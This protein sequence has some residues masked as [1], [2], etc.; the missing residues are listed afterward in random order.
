MIEGVISFILGFV[1]F[2]FIKSVYDFIEGIHSDRKRAKRVKREEEEYRR[3]MEERLDNDYAWLKGV[4]S[5]REDALKVVRIMAYGSTAGQGLIVMMEVIS[6]ELG[7]YDGGIYELR[8]I[9]TGGFNPD[10]QVS[11][12]LLYRDGRKRSAMG[13]YIS[14]LHIKLK[15]RFG[16]AVEEQLPRDE[17][18]DAYDDVVLTIYYEESTE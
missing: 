16:D 7:P 11:V 2:V 14:K 18:D 1:T 5:G 8:L 3:Q 12:K 9:P 4:T 13:D 10:I 17:S 6:E 15:S